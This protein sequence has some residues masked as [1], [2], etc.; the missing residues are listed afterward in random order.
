VILAEA[1]IPSE[2]VGLTLVRA[3]DQASGED[4]SLPALNKAI[5]YA[6][7]RRDGDALRQWALV[8]FNPE[9]QGPLIPIPFHDKDPIPAGV[10]F[11]VSERTMAWLRDRALDDETLGKLQPMTKLRPLEQVPFREALR[12]ALGGS[13]PLESTVL[14]LSDYH[15]D[16]VHLNL[17]AAHLDLYRM[18]LRDKRFDVASYHLARAYAHYPMAELLEA[19]IK[20]QTDRGLIPPGI[21]PGVMFFNYLRIPAPRTALVT[22]GA[23]EL[24]VLPPPALED[25]PDPLPPLVIPARQPEP[26]QQPQPTRSQR[27]PPGGPQRR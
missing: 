7:D 20:L 5:G 17:Y 6:T 2:P 10:Q 25:V 27:L 4:W 14:Q 3:V 18:Y 15:A 21:Q 13:T 23:F 1:L 9:E 16:H 22:S 12:K 24:S 11:R 19:W 8:L 26:A